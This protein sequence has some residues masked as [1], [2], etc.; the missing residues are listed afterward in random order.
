[1]KP[2]FVPKLK[3]GDL[4]AEYFDEEFTSLAPTDSMSPMC[5]IGKDEQDHFKGFSFSSSMMHTGRTPH[6]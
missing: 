5:E 6:P 1:M 4:G 3:K 2:E